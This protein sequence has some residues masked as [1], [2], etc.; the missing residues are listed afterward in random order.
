MK[1]T[2]KRNAFLRECM[3]KN[4]PE[5]V[6][7]IITDRMRGKTTQEREAIAERAHK[8]LLEGKLSEETAGEI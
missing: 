1:D 8:A 5:S 2:R 6:L 3:R 7:L 4:V